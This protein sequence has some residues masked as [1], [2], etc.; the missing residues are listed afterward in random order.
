MKHLRKVE[1]LQN[2]AL[3]IISNDYE[4]VSPH[5]KSLNILKFKDNTTLKNCLILHDF[6][7]KKLPTSFN[8]YFTTCKDLHTINTRSASK[9]RIFAPHVDTATYGR[10]SVTHE[11]ILSWNFL[12]DLYPAENFTLMPIN[13]FKQFIKVHF[14]NSYIG[15]SD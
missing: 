13:K 8:N 4:H 5:Y 6:I 10:K 7:N 1:V 2:G 3:H 12:T 15:T 14:T 9:G 11:A